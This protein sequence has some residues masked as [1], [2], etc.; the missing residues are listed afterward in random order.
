MSHRWGRALLLPTLAASVSA[1]FILDRVVPFSPATPEVE[2]SCDDLAQN[3]DES[4]VDCGGA[5]PPC[6]TDALPSCGDGAQ[7]QGE[8]GIDCGGP[9]AACPS[10]SDLA[11][12]AT[13][14]DVDCGGGCAPCAPGKS[15]KV[16]SDCT[17]GECD[18]T[19]R[20][21]V[22]PLAA[23]DTCPNA[24]AVRDRQAPV[25]FFTD[26]SFA[27][28]SG[29]EHGLGS[30]L[31]L[32]GLR[33][34]P[35]KSASSHVFVAGRE[36]ARYTAWNP[37]ENPSSRTRAR[38]L[39]SV[40]VEL[41]PE[42]PAGS[43]ELVVMVG[44]RRS[45]AITVDIVA[46]A[47]VLFVDPGYSG[48]GSDGSLA[49][50]LT[51]LRQLRE[52]TVIG[53]RGIGSGDI[54]FLRAGNYDAVDAPSTSVLD[55]VNGGVGVPG[56]AGGT[57][58]HGG[59]TPFAIVGYPLERAIV[60][61]SGVTGSVA[62]RLENPDVRVE[63]ANLDLTESELSVTF[64]FPGQGNGARIVGN[65]LRGHSPAG[66]L[67]QLASSGGF[68][69]LG[70][71]FLESPQDNGP[72][73]SQGAGAEPLLC[74]FA[75]NEMERVGDC[76]RFGFSN[77]HTLL[78]H[79]NCCNVPRWSDLE[80]EALH[81]GSSIHN[82]V[83]IGG[84]KLW[85]DNLVAD[86]TAPQVRIAHNTMLGVTHGL[87][88]TNPAFAT[89]QIVFANNVF[90]GAGTTTV[91]DPNVRSAVSAEGN[92]YHD[93]AGGTTPSG[94][95]SPI[96]ANLLLTASADACPSDGEYEPQR[97]PSASPALDAAVPSSICADYF[98]RVRGAAPDIG[99]VEAP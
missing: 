13:E 78:Y 77:V 41:G 25:I 45:N 65:R 20:C 12:N 39:D 26:T 8:S 43:V 93:V 82:N 40:I 84:G 91:A 61:V 34:G 58:P 19:K 22:P 73:I 44:G 7:N 60:G 50:P 71:R 42:T 56:L 28:R 46:N 30:Y 15:C 98:G 17:T 36:V 14:T 23:A 31:T 27:A 37:A 64:F 70:N 2:A 90:D 5:C 81:Q 38:G 57:G 80:L 59:T 79:D 48:A 97:A 3:G 29:G 63:I 21:G 11:A 69:V 32:Y 33:F 66:Y 86:A 49:Q 16:A 92:V 35:S 67:L 51:S 74:E 18:A 88:R 55:F 68:I 89:P 85:V 24:P 53:G 4:G 83:I 87:V 52:R 54:V 1:C 62:M 99:A 75:W 6:E 94:D 47:R 72:L 76:G 10:C 9:C 96:A 95:S